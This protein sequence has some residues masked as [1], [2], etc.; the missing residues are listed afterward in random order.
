M[1]RMKQIMIKDSSLPSIASKSDFAEAIQLCRILS[2]IQYNK[3]IYAQLSKSKDFSTNLQLHLIINHGAALYEGIKKFITLKNRLKN[4]R[5]YKK[6]QKE[7]E[8]VISTENTFV[9]K[10]LRKIRTKVAFHYDKQVIANTFEK[11]VLESIKSKEPVIFIEGKTE[12]V[13]DMNFPLADSLNLRYILGLVGGKDLNYK[14]KFKILS[15]Q[16]LKLSNSFC[17]ILQEI[18]PD[19]VEDDCE[20]LEVK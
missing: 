12:M 9:N 11:F 4:L 5:S 18:I 1:I 14:E 20:F 13:K 19:L 10:V 7:I 17:T 2:A 3:V 6:N 16:L 8:A 15:S